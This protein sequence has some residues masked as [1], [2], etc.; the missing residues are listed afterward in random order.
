MRGGNRQPLQK[1]VQ[2]LLPGMFTSGGNHGTRTNLRRRRHR[3][4]WDPK[5]D[6]T[7]IRDGPTLREKRQ[8]VRTGHGPDA[9]RTIPV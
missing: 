4:R 1:F 6:S 3:E 8:R 5:E 9:G 7:K 2:P